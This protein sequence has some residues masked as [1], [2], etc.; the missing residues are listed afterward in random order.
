[1]QSDYLKKYSIQVLETLAVIIAFSE[2]HIT[3]TVNVCHYFLITIHDRNIVTD[4]LCNENRW[5]YM[6]ANIVYNAKL[7]LL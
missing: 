4:V 3:D 7:S 2:M 5:K 6:T 1:M